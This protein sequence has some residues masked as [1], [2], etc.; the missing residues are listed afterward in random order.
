MKKQI[1]LKHAKPRRDFGKGFYTTRVQTQAR[2]FAEYTYRNAQFDYSCGNS[3][4]DPENAALVVL[5]IDLGA[6]ANLDTLA[7]VQPTADWRDFTR[8]CR[9]TG[10]SHKANGNKFPSGLWPCPKSKW[11]NSGFGGTQLS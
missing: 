11:G 9:H 2:R 8:Y 5:Q 7:F 6:L 3:L 4:L 1:E 10:G